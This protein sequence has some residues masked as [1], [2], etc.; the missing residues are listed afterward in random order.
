M[1]VGKRV[2]RLPQTWSRMSTVERHQK[3]QNIVKDPIDTLLFNKSYESYLKK[4]IKQDHSINNLLNE[5]EFSEGEIGKNLSKKL[6]FFLNSSKLA[7]PI[8]ESTSRKKNVYITILTQRQ[9]Y[10][11][12]H[13]RVINYTGETNL[14]G[15]FL[16]KVEKVSETL[17][18]L[19]DG[20]V[21]PISNFDKI[22]VNG[23]IGS[24]IDKLIM[25]TK[26]NFVYPDLIYSDPVSPKLINQIVKKENLEFV[27]HE[28][29]YKPDL[30][31]SFVI[32]KNIKLQGYDSL[33]EKKYDSGHQFFD[34]AGLT[35]N[36]EIYYKLKNILNSD[37]FSNSVDFNNSRALSFEINTVQQIESVFREK[38]DSL[39]FRAN[40]DELSI[41]LL[42][43]PIGVWI[44]LKLIKK[45]LAI[46][47][48]SDYYKTFSGIE[49]TTYKYRIEYV[50]HVLS[51]I[52]TTDLKKIRSSFKGLNLI[53]IILWLSRKFLV[54]TS[55]KIF[56]KKKIVMERSDTAIFD[57]G[58]LFR[59]EN[60]ARA[61]IEP[62]NRKIIEIDK[63][64]DFIGWIRPKK[65]YVFKSEKINY[66]IITDENIIKRK[67]IKLGSKK[68]VR[69]VMP[70]FS[71]KKI[72]ICIELL[73]N[74]VVLKK[75]FIESLSNFGML[76]KKY[77]DEIKNLMNIR[78]S[79]HYNQYQSLRKYLTYISAIEW[80]L[81]N[82]IEIRHGDLWNLLIQF[83][84]NTSKVKKVIKFLNKKIKFFSNLDIS[85]FSVQNTKLNE[86][87]DREQR[88]NIYFNMT[89]EE[90][91]RFDSIKNQTEKNKLMDLYIEKKQSLIDNN[92]VVQ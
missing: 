11:L 79:D 42:I 73:R 80:Q 66:E 6:R 30:T 35:D 46:N 24:F 50:V 51:R 18:M 12:D 52:F 43:V 82:K 49:T 55:K 48:D 45:S 40:L 31:T 59:R 60:F 78:E 41:Q 32:K 26:F 23:L 1:I 34:D 67:N 38:L 76:I 57:I 37:V 3:I 86:I 33:A 22:L 44:T 47:I 69:W 62:K 29:A 19:N 27:L 87:E 2:R 75:K 7:I 83:S 81:I 10:D 84:K 64:Y 20:M 8:I 74:Y 54:K 65:T 21:L 92:D 68:I 56:T 15:M 70:S 9:C 89:P 17:E 14:V 85:E 63:K 53:E 4:Y 25:K 13:N 39:N 16:P 36:T 72:N 90:K 71:N 61:L 77:N 58:S 28:K 88:F 91:L 5:Y